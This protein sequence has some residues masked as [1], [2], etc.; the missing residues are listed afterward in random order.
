MSEIHWWQE[1]RQVSQLALRARERSAP[2]LMQMARRA[3]GLDDFGPEPF[4]GA[5]ARL[6]EA[7][8]SDDRL[9]LLGRW[10]THWDSLRLLTNRLILREREK[11]DPSILSRSIDGPLF[12]LGL[13]RSGTS[14]LHRLF[15]EDPD[16]LVMRSWQAVYPY[17][18]HPAAGA[19]GGPERVQSQLGL[20]G[21]IA[22][23]LSKIH[24]LDA[25]KPQECGEI[26]AH[27]F[28]SRRFDATYDV[29][30]YRRWLAHVGGQLEAMRFHRRFLQHLQRR[31]HGVWALKWP[32]HVFA[33]EALRAVYPD[34]R[35]IAC[36]RDPA[37]VL[38][39]V[40]RLTE[41]MRRPF[42]RRLDRLELGRQVLGDWTDGAGRLTAFHRDGVWPPERVFHLH[43]KALTAD[44]LS[45]MQ[46]LYR[47]FGLPFAPELRSRLEAYIEANP[48]GGYGRNSY[49]LADFGLTADAV[50]DAFGDYASCFDVES[51]AAA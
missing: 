29:P 41:V 25:F 11:A 43:F 12:I 42:V 44:P 47:H 4:E 49:R 3:T 17:P 2:E 36:H 30:S 50:R 38:P 15:A 16:V 19:H 21:R 48:Q 45:T 18:D 9:S 26:T 10:A 20:F 31:R 1:A 32:D 7:Y 23:E 51:E 39:S 14:F 40:A 46:R 13:P 34:A 37:K 22:P 6:L 24:P 35:I 5:L 8:R 28:R 27:A 33:L